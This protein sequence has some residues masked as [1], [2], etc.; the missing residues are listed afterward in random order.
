MQA[1]FRYPGFEVVD[2]GMM[3]SS[4]D[5]GGLEFRGTEV[6]LKID[7]IEFRFTARAPPDGQ[8]PVEPVSYKDDDF[9]HG[10][11][12]SARS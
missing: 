5:D 2:E 10:N 4:I 1:A 9:T 8:N 7:R 3:V 6:T 12:R 11:L